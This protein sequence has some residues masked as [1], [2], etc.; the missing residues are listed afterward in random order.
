MLA[1][2]KRGADVVAH[3]GH[4]IKD[5]SRCIMLYPKNGLGIG[6]VPIMLPESDAW[7]YTPD[8]MEEDAYIRGMDALCERVCKEFSLGYPSSKRKSDIAEVIENAIEAAI[9]LPPFDHNAMFGPS[10]EQTEQVQEAV[11]EAIRNAEID[12]GNIK[13][14]VGL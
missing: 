1:V 9:R 6:T 5:G 11:K 4:N 10:K 2:K 8:T 3:V 12:S 13:M 7:M 14:V